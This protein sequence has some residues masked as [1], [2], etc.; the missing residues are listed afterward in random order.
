MSYREKLF[1]PLE[2]K[3]EQQIIAQRLKKE[4]LPILHLE[5]DFS[6]LF[7]IT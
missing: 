7:F 5:N 2:K 6:Q 4:I 1:N 3:S